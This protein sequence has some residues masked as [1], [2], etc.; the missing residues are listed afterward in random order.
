M[1]FQLSARTQ[2]IAQPAY[3]GLV[4][5]PGAHRSLAPLETAMRRQRTPSET[6]T[7]RRLELR[8]AGRQRADRRAA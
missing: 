4:K 1:N 8:C 3:E 6:A 5:H 2:V 7:M